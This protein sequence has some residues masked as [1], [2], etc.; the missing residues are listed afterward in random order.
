[1][2][3]AIAIGIPLV[4]GVYL[5]TNISYFTVLSKEEVLE[6]SAVAVVSTL[7]RI[8][9]VYE[10]KIKFVLF[11]RTLEMIKEQYSIYSFSIYITLHS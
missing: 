3:L 11:E 1:M 8:L 7:I 5:L 2:P 6:S 10:V 4:T 9:S